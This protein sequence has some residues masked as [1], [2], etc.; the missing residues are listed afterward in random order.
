MIVERYNGG[1]SPSLDV[2]HANWTAGKVSADSYTPSQL[3]SLGYA[4]RRPNPFILDNPGA[5]IA[6]FCVEDGLVR[7][8]LDTTYKSAKILIEG[9]SSPVGP[10]EELLECE[11]RRGS[12]EIALP[13]R[14]NR[15]TFF[16]LTELETT[17][18]RLAH[19]VAAASRRGEFRPNRVA[20]IRSDPGEIRRRIEGCVREGKDRETSVTT[21]TPRMVV[22][23]RASL[24][25]CVGSSLTSFWIQ[26]GYNVELV[27]VDGFPP[28][29][30]AFR[31]ALKASIA[32][33][34]ASGAAYILLVGDANDFREFTQ[35]WPGEWE[36]IR[37]SR[38]ASGYPA[39]GQ[40]ERDLIPTFTVPDTRPQEEGMSYFSPY[41]FADQS[42]ADVDD[43]GLP[44]VAL[45]RLPV[46]SEAEVL[47]YATKLWGNSWDARKVALFVGDRQWDV[48][49]DGARA[50]SAAT[51]V[52]NALPSEATVDSLLWSQT[53][54][55]YVVNQNE[56][57]AARS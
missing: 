29:A 38:I 32:T 47:A 46:A 21:G 1:G 13:A 41:W 25:S 51:L 17:G 15:F 42:Y 45:G 4:A 35:P 53:S 8:E 52:K 34:V 16:Q 48:E 20:T 26:K 10:W 23:T 37:Q 6:M 22:Y 3:S 36:A 43:D 44:D 27:S 2:L 19:R 50:R 55:L 24:S 30:D 9:A 31:S 39:Q 5:E 57:F 18:R 54:W 14:A 7:W 40:P 28:Q 11:P 49:G 56:T 12:S 33:Y